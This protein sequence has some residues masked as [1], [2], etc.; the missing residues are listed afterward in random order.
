MLKLQTA[1][2]QLLSIVLLALLATMAMSTA[3]GA[4]RAAAIEY[5]FVE[6][7]AGL[8]DS[9]AAPPGVSLRFLAITTLDGFKVDAALW[10]PE[11]QRA[12]GPLVITVHGSGGNFTG[13]P[14]GFLSRGLA[15]KGT[16]VLA[17]NTRQHDGGVNKDNFLDTRRDIEAAVYTGRALGYPALVLHGHSLGN[18]QVQYY[19]AN[20]WDPDI[21]A[22]ILSGMFGNLPWKSRHIL[23]ENEDNFRQLTEAANA[24]LRAGTAADVL[25]VRMGWV[26]GEQVP[27]SATHFLTYRLRGTR[28]PHGPYSTP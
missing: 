28:V 23:I 5:D 8:P 21:K 26:T 22:V 4:Q 25:P 18:I 14:Q 19:A 1:L 12:G 13:P 20:N 7:P 16:S 17:I 3:H 6:R 24:A 27:I 10:E 2:S 9:F 11:T 15:G